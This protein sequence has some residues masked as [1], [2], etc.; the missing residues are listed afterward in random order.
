MADLEGKAA[1][2]TGGAGG[3]GRAT[4][5]RLHED[6]AKVAAFDRDSEG[7]RELRDN[8]GEGV[9]TVAGD[10]TSIEDLDRLFGETNS[11]FGPVDA[12]VANAASERMQAVDEVSSEDFD[13]RIGVVLKS[14]FFTVQRALPYL[15][16]PVSVVLVGSSAAYQGLPNNSLYQASKAGLRSLARGMSADLKDRGVRV[17]C[18]SPGL[19][20]TGIGDAVG[21]SDPDSDAAK[22]FEEYIKQIPL[23]RMANPEEVAAGVA[24]LASEDSSYMLGSDLVMDGGSTQL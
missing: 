21:L 18:L 19:A 15:S 22:L 13:E 8:L 24:F 9:L 4:V 16:D 14:P 12:V 1:V 3:I 23:G 7:L 20:D 2:V 17:N 6:G 10:V 5:E 11:E